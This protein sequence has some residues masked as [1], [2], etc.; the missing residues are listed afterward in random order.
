MNLPAY[1]VKDPDT[2]M[3]V[4]ISPSDCI[5]K[6]TIIP[7]NAKLMRTP[8]G[9]PSLSAFPD[10]TSNPGP[11]IPRGVLDWA[12]GTHLLTRITRIIHLTYLQ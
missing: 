1:S 9:P 11:M 8:A 6:K 3:I 4:A 10:P 5:T 2:G 12:I 7:T